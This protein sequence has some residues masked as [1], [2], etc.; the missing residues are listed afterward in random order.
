MGI[1][2]IIIHNKDGVCHY[3]LYFSLVRF[4][5]NL[6]TWAVMSEYFLKN[7]DIICHKTE[8][9]PLLGLSAG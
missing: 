5:V 7:S 3:F 1:V 8:N 9:R 4:F 6:T 2:N